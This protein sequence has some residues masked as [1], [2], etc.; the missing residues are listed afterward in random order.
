MA[1]PISTFTYIG[2]FSKLIVY[3]DEILRGGKENLG[4]SPRSYKKI[5]LGILEANEEFNIE[6]EEDTKK[7]E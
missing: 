5:L 3:D 1:K 2:E 4:N 6:K 7:T